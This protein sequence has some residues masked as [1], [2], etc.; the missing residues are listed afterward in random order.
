MSGAK[1]HVEGILKT[2]KSGEDGDFWRLLVPGLYKMWCEEGE[3]KSRMVEIEVSREYQVLYN[4]TLYGSGEGSN[5]AEH[6]IFEPSQKSESFSAIPVSL[7]GRCAFSF[8][9]TMY[10]GC[11]CL[12]VANQHSHLVK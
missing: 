10:I 2:V 8:Y 12:Q 6:Y 1:I 9:S 3:R 11:L 4:F 5:E 7:H